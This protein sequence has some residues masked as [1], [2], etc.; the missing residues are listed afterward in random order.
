MIVQQKQ[1]NNFGQTFRRLLISPLGANFDARGWS[2]TPGMNF[3][4]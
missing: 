1:Q 2:L 4:P 3:V